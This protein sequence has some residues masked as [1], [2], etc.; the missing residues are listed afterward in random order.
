MA[1]IPFDIPDLAAIRRALVRS[2]DVALRDGAPMV[3]T[4]NLLDGD[5]ADAAFTVT[6]QSGRVVTLHLF[7]DPPDAATATEWRVGM[8]ARLVRCD[9]TT[10]QPLQG[11]IVQ[12]ATV[13]ALGADGSDVFAT[14]EADVPMRFDAETG[15]ST[16]TRKRHWRLLPG[17]GDE[18]AVSGTIL[19]AG[20][21]DAGLKP[22]SLADHVA[23]ATGEDKR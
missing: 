6:L 3:S 12:P 11:V 10:G 22:A 18:A 17:T 13:T 16:G 14:A 9:E 23:T 1:D 20:T 19:G 8:A 2:P 5:P 21:Y 4:L 15:F 7:L